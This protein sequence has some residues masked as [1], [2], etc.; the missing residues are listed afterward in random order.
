MQILEY[1]D[2]RG[3]V[4]FRE[5]FDALDR[6]AAAKVEIAVRRLEQGNTSSLKS[7]GGG[8]YECRIH[9]GPGYR[10]Y[11]GYDGTRIV[12]LLG[13][14]TKKRQDDDIETARWRWSDYQ[15]RKDRRGQTTWH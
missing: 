3:R 4:P 15:R 9:Y 12:I 14:G 1:R 13:G 5:W 11:L 6:A 2:A 8:L 10:V 7:V